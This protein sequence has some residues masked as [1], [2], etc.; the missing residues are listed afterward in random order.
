MFRRRFLQFIPLATALGLIP[1]KAMAKGTVAKG[2]T[3][4]V[5]YRVK[6][7]SCITC[8]TGLDTMLGEQR[9]IASSKSTYPEGIV[10]IVFD[11]KQISKQQIADFIAEL[12]FTAESAS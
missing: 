6:G 12:G 7:F 8:A 11:P 10:K 5:T 1:V 2:K 9:G 4:L 3:E